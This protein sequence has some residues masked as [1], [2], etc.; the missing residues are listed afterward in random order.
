[1]QHD[2]HH[3]SPQPNAAAGFPSSTYGPSSG[4]QKQ[5]HRSKTDSNAS[6][7]SMDGARVSADVKCPEL[8]ISGADL[9]QKVTLQ[10]LYKKVA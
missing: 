8:L 1:M 10:K 7:G 3:S 9:Q 6:A 4:E 5:M 2:L